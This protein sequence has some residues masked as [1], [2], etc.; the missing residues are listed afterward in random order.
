MC[1][2]TLLELSMMYLPITVKLIFKF[3]V[4]E[5]RK[6]TRHLYIPSSSN[7]MLSTFKC[8]GCDVLLKYALGPKAAGDDHSLA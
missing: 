5:F 4:G 1:N 7:K 8:A 6:S 2:E 3:L